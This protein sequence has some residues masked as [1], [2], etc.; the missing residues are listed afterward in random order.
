MA[1]ADLVKPRWWP[2]FGLYLIAAISMAIIGFVIGAIFGGRSADPNTL[3]V[4]LQDA[5]S[6]LIFTPFQA[7]IVAVVY[8]D[9][10]TRRE[11]NDRYNA[12]MT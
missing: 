3:L 5:I 9:L 12:S 10:R 1:S 8:F 7:A 6:Q 4:V 2:T 11:G